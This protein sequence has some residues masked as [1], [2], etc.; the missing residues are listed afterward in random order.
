MST[1]EMAERLGVA[2][3][4]ITVLE[5]AEV[6]ETIGLA[7]LRQAADALD[8]DLAYALVPRTT[9]DDAVHRQARRRAEAHLVPLR[10]HSRL[11]QQSTDAASTDALVNDL[12][13]S[14]IDRRGLWTSSTTSR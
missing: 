12:A 3:Q 2:Q 5:R 6:N 7:T 9:L 14:L 1:T 10:H 13:E 8:C 4:R 11:E